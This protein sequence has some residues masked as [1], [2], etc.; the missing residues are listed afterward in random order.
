MPTRRTP[1]SVA[2]MSALDH[3]LSR[4]AAP[5]QAGAP[6]ATYDVEGGGGL[7]LHVREWGNPEG[8]L[9]L[10]I[11]GWSQSQLCWAR[12]VS[13][14]L[15]QQFHIVTYDLRG[16]GMSE[17]PRSADCYLDAQLWADDLASVIRRTGRDRAVLVAWSYGGFVVS[18]YLRAYGDQKI[19]GL[20][21]VGECRDAQAAHVRPHRPGTPRDRAGHLRGRPGHEHRRP[22]TVPPGLHRPAA[23]QRRLDHGPV[24][25]HGRPAR[26]QGR[27]ARTRDRRRRCPVEPF[28]AGAG[29][30][31][32]FRRDRAALDGASTFSMSARRRNR[33]GTTTSGTCPSTKTQRGSTASSASRG[34]VN[35][36]RAADRSGSRGWP[37]AAMTT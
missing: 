15:S 22:A 32:T 35:P 36:S 21:L 37:T 17:K 13:G 31:R 24:L 33:P 6:I 29:Q 5:M 25:E 28:A 11:H 26:G 19:A 18:D 30:P 2:P 1:R 12:Q 20:N 10:F 9:I 14:P 27:T 34:S 23:Q 4:G 8:S 3:N 16:H 7:T